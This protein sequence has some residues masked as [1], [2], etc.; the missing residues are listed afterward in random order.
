MTNDIV[1]AISVQLFEIFGAEYAIYTE[2]IEQDLQEP[3]FY[4]DVVDVRRERIIG[5]RHY[6]NN[7][8]DICYFS[9]ET[10]RKRDFRYVADTLLDEMEYISLA[11]GDLLHATKMSCDVIDDV[12]HFF[13]NY[14]LVLMKESAIYQDMEN[15]VIETSSKEE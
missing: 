12:L 3:C 5:R 15:L 7:A 9:N 11:N 14:N 10:D 13:V 2:N 8:F 4:I 6:S 1:D